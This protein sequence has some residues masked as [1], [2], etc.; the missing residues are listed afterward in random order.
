MIH[1]HSLC[2]LFSLLYGCSLFAAD[3]TIRKTIQ[4]TVVDQ[5]GKP[6]AGAKLWYPYAYEVQKSKYVDATT[7]TDSQ[8]RYSLDVPVVIENDE[9]K[10][11]TGSEVFCY[12]PGYSLWA[13]PPRVSSDREQKKIDR[14]R[15][16]TWGDQ[17]HHEL[18]P[19]TDTAFVVL[20]TNGKPVEGVLVE[21]QHYDT[22]IG[23]NLVPEGARKLVGGRTD[24]DGRVKLPALAHDRIFVVRLSSKKYGVQTRQLVM[25]PTEPTERTITLRPV[26]RIEG[27]V[28][29]DH[30]AWCGGI[31]L[32]FETEKPFAPGETSR[33]PF[34][35]QGEARA[36]TDKTGR[37]EVPIIACGNLKV[38]H[39]IYSNDVHARPKLPRW[40]K[41]AEGDTAKLEIV[42]ERLVKIHGSIVAGDTRQPM[43]AIKIH[44]GYGSSGQ[45]TDVVSDSGGKFS[46]W[47]LPGKVHFRVMNLYNTKY[48]QLGFPKLAEVPDDAEDYEVGPIEAAPTKPAKGLLIDQDG[49]PV[50]NARV[51]G[52]YNNHL[53]SSGETDAKGEFALKKMPTAI[54]FD[55][56]TYHVRLTRHETRR[57]SDGDVQIEPGESF[58]IRVRR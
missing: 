21:P 18:A 49:K 35:T 30:L 54:R 47:V 32:F 53:F 41:L 48:V 2:L 45:S 40:Q 29:A 19:L 24:S 27:R 17:K 20:D 13:P 43:E 3:P 11:S 1:R 37:F 10:R 12:A 34:P 6:I 44:I 50:A 9:I 25:K 55:D 4:G 8:G 57:W 5:Q 14:E 28:V 42:M 39:T 38:R 33:P 22:R 52:Y 23:F 7:E 51:S 36:I 56:A 16:K 26:G 15:K 58:T 31:Q 46:A